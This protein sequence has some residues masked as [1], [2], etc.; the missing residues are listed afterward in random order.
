MRTNRSILAAG[1]LFSAALCA[2]AQLTT[3]V[4]NPAANPSGHGLWT[5][6]AN[7]T[8]GV[9]PNN[10][11]KVVLNISG[12]RAC[13]VSSAIS[14]GQLVAGDNGPGGTLIFTNGASLTTS[15]DNWCAIGYNNTNLTRVESGG[16]VSFGFQLWIGFSPGGDGTLMINGGTVTVADMFGLGWNGGKGTVHVNGGTLN[17]SLWNSTLSIQGASV[18]DIGAGTVMIA[19]NQVASVGNFVSS[20]RITGYG[21]TGTVGSFFDGVA[22]KTI[23]TA[24]PGGGSPA[25]NTASL[26]SIKLASSTLTFSWPTSSVYYSLQSTT[27]LAATPVVWQTVTNNVTTRKN[28]VSHR[29]FSMD[30]IRIPDSLDIASRHKAATHGRKDHLDRGG[31][32]TRTNG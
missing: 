22:N 13:V 20:G 2:G 25:T 3:T 9:V 29:S 14:A 31:S 23:L 12:A 30:I 1:L 21:G 6:T 28:D 10:T 5:E 17:L 19:G 11:N 27:N 16:A 24:T 4:W 8:G 15:A 18:L 32:R 26:L 7:W